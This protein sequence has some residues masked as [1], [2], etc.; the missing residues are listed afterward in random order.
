MIFWTIL[1]LLGFEIVLTLAWARGLW[2]RLS[3]HS[4]GRWLRALLALFTSLVLAS[5]AWFVASRLGWLPR[6]R[7]ITALGMVWAVFAVPLGVLPCLLCWA[8]ADTVR[9]MRRRAGRAPATPATEPASD[10]SAPSAASPPAAPVLSRREA[11]ATG[12]AGFPL[13]LTLGA[14][15]KGIA[16]A[17]DFRV[18]QVRLPV[19]GLPPALAGL[20]IAHLTDTHVGGFTPSGNLRRVAAAVA[21][22]KP[23]LI[24]FTGDLMDHSLADV[25]A[26]LDFCERLRSIA[27]LVMCEGNHDRVWGTPDGRERLRAL[28]WERKFDWLVAGDA[29]TLRLRGEPLQVL[30]ASWSRHP[31]DHV[32]RVAEAA[33]RRDERAFPLLLIHHPDAFDAA[34]AAGFPLTLAGHSHG[35]QLMLAGKYGGGPV[36]FEHWSGPYHKHGAT[37][38]VSNG[39]GHWFPVRVGAPAEVSMLTLERA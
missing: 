9:F 28:L 3:G 13:V 31:A 32:A 37:L 38:H 19:P 25:D 4:G 21:A 33:A 14:T 27:P 18:Q 2:R 34:A 36:F 7:E 6:E 24:A 15:G 1:A 26:A 16:E 12:L 11:L 22:E 23:D 17:W 20:R 29:R 10:P 8:L 39:I 5:M 30:G 35:G